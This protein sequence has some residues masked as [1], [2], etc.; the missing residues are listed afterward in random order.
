MFTTA[1]HS[2][3]NTVSLSGSPHQDSVFRPPTAGDKGPVSGID[4]L[5]KLALAWRDV[6][7]SAASQQKLHGMITS[8]G[9]SGAADVVLVLEKT[10][11]GRRSVRPP[12]SSPAPRPRTT[13]A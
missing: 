10:L 5:P 1:R 11:K 13:S 6:L 2:G 8:M 7:F 4:S 12:G 3:P 9:G